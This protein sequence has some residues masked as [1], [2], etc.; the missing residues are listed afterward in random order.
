MFDCD[1]GYKMFLEDVFEN[2]VRMIFGGNW[3]LVFV[4]WMNVVSL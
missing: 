3:S 1:L 2:E 4:F